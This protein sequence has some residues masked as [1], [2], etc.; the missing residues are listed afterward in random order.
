MEL[1]VNNN[2]VFN[3][4]ENVKELENNN[5]Y[6][7]SIRKSLEKNLYSTVL[8]SENTGVNKEKKKDWVK[9]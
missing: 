7:S 1:E 3:T 5:E 4:F 8:S 2:G 9:S 6:F